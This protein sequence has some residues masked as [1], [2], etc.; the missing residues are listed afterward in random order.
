VEAMDKVIAVTDDPTFKSYAQ[1]L[2]AMA[3]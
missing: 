1:Q 3:K 2:R